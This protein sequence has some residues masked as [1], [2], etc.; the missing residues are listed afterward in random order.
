[1]Q[2]VGSLGLGAVSMPLSAA[3]AVETQ[4][5]E[6]PVFLSAKPVWLKGMEEKKSLFV[7]FRAVF[8]CPANKETASHA[9]GAQ[10]HH[11]AS[12]VRH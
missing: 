5:G 3:A 1:V 7:G 11:A 6:R 4:S 9:H 2:G 10:H 12:H 8:E